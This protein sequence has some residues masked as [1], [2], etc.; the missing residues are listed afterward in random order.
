MEIEKTPKP[1]FS[2]LF[3]DFE[4]NGWSQTDFSI[5][6]TKAFC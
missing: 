4:K 3:Y 5:F 6:K 2:Q 1:L